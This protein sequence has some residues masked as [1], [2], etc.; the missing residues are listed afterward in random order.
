[1]NDRA[2]RLAES[3]EQ[4]EIDVLLVSGPLNV[5][6][7]TGYSGSNGIALVGSRIRTFVTDFRYVEQAASEVDASF[8]H[9]T[10]PLELLQAVEK[11]LPTGPLRLG[12]EDAQLTVRQH[13]R[14]RELMSQRVE[15][16]PAGSLVEELRLV[17]GP[18]E[19]DAIR[20]AAALADNAFEAL[21]QQGLL[22]RTEREL[23]QALERAM[24][25]RGARRSSFDCIVAAGPQ[26]ALP[27]G[28]PRDVLLSAGDMV[29]IDWGAELAGYHSDCTRTVA[30]GEP[31][32]E[33]REVYDLVL[34]AQ[35]AGLGAVRSAAAA[36][37]V[38]G[39][40]RQIIEEAGHGERFGHGLGHGV[41]LDIHEPP[42]LSQRSDEILKPGSTVT[43]EP[44]VYLPGRF[45]VRIE[46]LVVVG[47]EGPEILTGIA[48]ELRI[49]D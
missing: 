41:G 13:G 20:G 24:L 8:E 26:G 32:V 4:L 1:M 15:L 10:A 17:K 37:D 21:M 38:D 14:L 46:D 40:A 33:A 22:G 7:L 49:V 47:D 19:L 36:R 9:V 3:L 48:K 43:V 45:G 39:V 6:Y 34:R 35:S 2:E 16:V 28:E 11:I 42:R 5:R 29:V 25:E 31:G 23:A 44:G 27:H 12:F 18:G 30:V